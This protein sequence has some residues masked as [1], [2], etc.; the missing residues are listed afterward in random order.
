MWENN[1]IEIFINHFPEILKK[2][3][4]EKVSALDE[5]V[6]KGIVLCSFYGF[7]EKGSSW[8]KFVVND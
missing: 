2:N 5:M 1:I 6:E 4:E 7:D 3:E 8:A